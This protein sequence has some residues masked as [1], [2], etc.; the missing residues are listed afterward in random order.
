MKTIVTRRT[1]YLS[2]ALLF[3]VT[4]CGRMARADSITVYSNLDSSAGF[5]PI[6]GWVVDGGLAA[7][8][9]IANAF[10]PSQTVSLADAQLALGSIF[11]LDT[12]SVVLESSADGLPDSVLA[13]LTEQ[14]GLVGFPAGGL[15][16]YTCS[17]CPV[18]EAGVQY[19]LVA[20]EPDA[21]TVA[22]WNWND[23]GDDSTGDFVYNQTGSIVGPWSMDIGDPR[24]AFE[25]QG[26]ATPEGPTL[27]LFGAGLLAISCMNKRQ[28][29]ARK[30]AGLHSRPR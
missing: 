9:V 3:L 23:T 18:L 6:Q 29:D 15:V 10:T 5:V 19:W 2:C 16:E 20:Q 1:L 28:W 11:G 8:Q 25:V 27:A 17:A 12:V 14:S 26:T 22:E 4:W 24:G 21:D 30:R 7:D 13:D